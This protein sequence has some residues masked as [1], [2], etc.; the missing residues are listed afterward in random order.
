MIVGGSSLV[1]RPSFCCSTVQYATIDGSSLGKG[2]GVQ[3]TDQT[4]ITCTFKI[5]PLYPAD[6]K[7]EKCEIALLLSVGF[8]I[9][10]IWIAVLCCK[11]VASQLIMVIRRR[12]VVLVHLQYAYRVLTHSHIC[13]DHNVTL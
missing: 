3:F 2:L 12:G 13:C 4:S 8:V 9:V 7:M 5:G 11:C 6:M 10:V 1:S